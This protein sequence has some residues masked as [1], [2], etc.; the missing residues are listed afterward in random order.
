MHR[1]NKSYQTRFGKNL[2]LPKKAMVN[3]NSLIT[4]N[5]NEEEV[6]QRESPV[7]DDL[8]FSGYSFEE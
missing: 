2:R 8:E 6:C 1:K 3:S 5:E 4:I 7:L